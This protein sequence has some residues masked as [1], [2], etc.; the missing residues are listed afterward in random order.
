[1]EFVDS[2]RDGY[3]SFDEYKGNKFFNGYWNFFREKVHL[4]Q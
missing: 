3:L 2:D 1:M 4:Q